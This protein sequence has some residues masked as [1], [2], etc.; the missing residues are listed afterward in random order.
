MTSRNPWKIYFIRLVDSVS[1]ACFLFI[2][3]VVLFT[4]L[5]AQIF[6]PILKFNYF[7]W[8]QR[9]DDAFRSLI[10]PVIPAV[11]NMAL[12]FLPVWLFFFV[13]L[14]FHQRDPKFIKLQTLASLLG[15]TVFP[16]GTI[17]HGAILYLLFFDAETRGYLMNAS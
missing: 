12:W 1:F 3:A 13:L 5:Q 17:L 4:V 6:F 16:W 9:P 7:M 15:L 14:R 10:S 8:E 2:F 11:I